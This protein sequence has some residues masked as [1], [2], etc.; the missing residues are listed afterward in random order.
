MNGD[1]GHA[2]QMHAGHQDGEAAK[3]YHYYMSYLQSN[4]CHVAAQHQ[5]PIHGMAMAMDRAAIQH[6]SATTASNGLPSSHSTSSGDSTGTKESDEDYGGAANNNNKLQ[7]APSALTH[8]AGKV[9]EAEG[10]FGDQG[11]RAIG[12][13]SARA[14]E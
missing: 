10:Y 13:P 7:M 6:Q 12:T 8:A 2:G 5:D 4:A 9:N 11:P 3:N 1:H 14:G